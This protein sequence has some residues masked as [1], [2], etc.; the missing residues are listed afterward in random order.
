MDTNFCLAKLQEVLW[1]RRTFTAAD[2]AS[3]HFSSH[4]LLIKTL[5][6][7]RRMRELKTFKQYCSALCKNKMSKI[8]ITWSFMRATE[9]PLA[10][11]KIAQPLYKSC[12]LCTVVWFCTKVISI[13]EG[14]HSTI[15]P[16]ILQ[17]LSCFCAVSAKT[18]CEQEQTLYWVML[19]HPPS[20]T[21]Q[22]AHLN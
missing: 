19:D 2:A 21:R 7:S 6:S 18:C 3:M 16:N 14:N 17:L 15:M 9:I 11:V 4:D 22:W 20:L 8:I 5:L 1:A 13:F 10:T 12:D